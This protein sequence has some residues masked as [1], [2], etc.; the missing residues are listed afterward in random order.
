MEK[1]PLRNKLKKID[2]P[3]LQD[4]L[5]EKQ[6]PKTSPSNEKISKQTLSNKEK[7]LDNL[8]KKKLVEDNSKEHKK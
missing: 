1:K 3:L 8:T 5:R 2:T 7:M 4:T 6:E